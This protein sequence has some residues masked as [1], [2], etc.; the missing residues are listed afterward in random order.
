MTKWYVIFVA[1]ILTITYIGLK[2]ECV[3]E[4][5][6]AYIDDVGILVFFDGCET[7]SVGFSVSSNML[8][9]KSNRGK[10]S[11]EWEDVAYLD[12][13]SAQD[14]GLLTIAFSN[15]NAHIIG[16]ISKETYEEIKKAIGD[17]IKFRTN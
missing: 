15:G 16:R 1:V 17:E 8:T 6:R 14:A 4:E 5:T 9:V 13:D 7:L 3:P 2:P 10:Y 11:V 12:Y